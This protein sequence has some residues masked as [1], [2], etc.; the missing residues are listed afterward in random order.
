MGKKSSKGSSEERNLFVG[1]FVS[2]CRKN[3]IRYMKISPLTITPQLSLAASEDWS[4]LPP[5]VD[6]FSL[7]LSHDDY[8]F[9]A[10]KSLAPLPRPFPL[11]PI[12]AR[13]VSTGPSVPR[14]SPS[15]SG[16][17]RDRA[18]S[19]VFRNNSCIGANLVDR[20]IGGQ[21]DHRW[22]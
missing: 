12:P 8:F 9:L 4:S 11:S 10:F 3:N 21:Q 16:R 2:P 13:P 15:M 6:V 22:P 19:T 7:G 14:F 18:L 5:P 17:S 1:C 20:S